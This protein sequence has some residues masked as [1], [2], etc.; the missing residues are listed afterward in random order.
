[1]SVNLDFP[2]KDGAGRMRFVITQQRDRCP[3]RKLCSGTVVGNEVHVAWWSSVPLYPNELKDLGDKL[4]AVAEYAKN[5][6]GRRPDQRGQ[7]G[8]GTPGAGGLPGDEGGPPADQVA[9]EK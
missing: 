9:E 7:N 8:G 3:R 1:M 6:T 5:A 4:E 2:G